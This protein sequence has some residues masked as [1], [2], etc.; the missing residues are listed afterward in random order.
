MLT[1][2][3]TAHWIASPDIDGDKLY[4][5]HLDILWL[6]NA[7]FDEVILI[8]MFYVD[9]EA[10]DFLTVSN[11]LNHLLMVFHNKNLCI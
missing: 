5:Y 9:I 11:Y 7:Q 8:D 6:I 4:D 1:A 10:N 2:E 3:M